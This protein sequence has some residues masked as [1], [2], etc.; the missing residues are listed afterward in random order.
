MKLG[1]EQIAETALGLMDEVG[2][3][4]LSTR[5]LAARLGVKQ[6]ALYWHFKSRRDLLDAMNDLMLSGLSA[7]RAPRSGEALMD[8]L[9]RGAREFRA[10]LCAHRDG[11]R[12]HAGTE[13]SV[14]DLA[15]SERQM[16]FMV[17]SGFAAADAFDLLVAISRYTLGCVLEEQAD[18]ERTPDS[19]LDQQVIDYPYLSKGLAHYRGQSHAAAFESGL[20]LLL[21][22]AAIQLQQRS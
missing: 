10:G 11:A 15:P 9:A 5:A 13:A 22:G 12:L 18:A 8:F 7:S 21:A 19:T 20:A 16:E 2:L 6:P 4:A 17:V 14:E 3:D 1:R